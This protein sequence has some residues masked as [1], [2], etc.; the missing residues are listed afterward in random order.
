MEV[1]DAVAALGFEI[2]DRPLGNDRLG[3]AHVQIQI[4]RAALQRDLKGAIGLVL[5]VLPE[6]A[7]EVD[8]R[9]D[10]LV[11]AAPDGVADQFVEVPL[12]VLDL[13]I[14]GYSCWTT[15]PVMGLSRSVWTVVGPLVG[16]LTLNW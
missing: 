15:S 8:R 12:P 9:V 7:P 1:L 6:L 4:R 16:H 3:A 5:V 13:G 2:N 10:P 14:D 11:A